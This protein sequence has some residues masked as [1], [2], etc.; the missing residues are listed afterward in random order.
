MNTK[1]DISIVL[2]L[3]LTCKDHGNLLGAI[4]PSQ[5]LS[6]PRL[7]LFHSIIEVV[8]CSIDVLGFCPRNQGNVL[9]GF[10][11]QQALLSLCCNEIFPIAL[12]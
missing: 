10:R 7:R 9:L 8:T 2:V 1:R 11:Q 12:S 6:L 4:I 5:K 3:N